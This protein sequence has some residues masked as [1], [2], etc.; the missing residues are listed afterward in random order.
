M[1]I[2]FKYLWDKYKINATGVLHVGASEGQEADAYYTN[3]IRRTLWIEALPD[4]FMTLKRNIEKYPHA[5]AICSCVSDVDN[6]MVSFRVA[7][8][9]GQSSSMFEFDTHAIQHPTVKFTKVIELLTQRLDTILPAF[10]VPD[11]SLYS[12]LNMDLQGAELKALKGMGNMLHDI[13]YAYIEVN[14]QHLYKDCPL[15]GEIDEYLAK[16]GLYGVET[17]MTNFGWGDKF[18]IRK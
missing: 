13:N 17:K 16:Y 5:F 10:Q 2:D 4:V 8:N 14:E 7:N 9:G 12:F 18:Y 11:L 1:L 6:E 15:V 3:G